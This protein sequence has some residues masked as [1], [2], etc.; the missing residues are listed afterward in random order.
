MVKASPSPNSNAMDVDIGNAVA[1][2]PTLT[3][4]IKPSFTTKAATT[5]TSTSTPT[6]STAPSP[7]PHRIKEK[8]KL[9]PLPSGNGL[10]SS[11]LFGGPSDP[12]E[13]PQKAPTVIIEVN[14]TSDENKVINFTRL[15]ESR[16]GVDAL[17]PRIAANRARLARVAA[18]GAALENAGKDKSGKGGATASGDEDMS[19]DN[20]DGDGA[21]NSNVEMGGMGGA[22]TDDAT[23]ENSG[24]PPPKKRR[25]KTDLYD[26]DDPFID[27]S[28][29][30][31]EENAVASK[32][33]FF[34]YSG[35]LVPEGE[36][37]TVERYF[38]SLILYCHG[39]CAWC[40]HCHSL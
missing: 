9:P 18:A 31:W 39:F 28:E 30:A 25:V 21:E 35:P 6:A 29:M 33:G 24:K 2:K 23:K 32:D 38:S 26:R 36:K 22:G 34:V 4:N 8:D 10:L 17:Y 11:S 16:Y 15:A 7:K 14:L 1:S 5:S 3:A 12:N 27:D 40:I 19:L 37:I 13:L 20:S